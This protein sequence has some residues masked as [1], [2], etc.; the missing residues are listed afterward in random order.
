[1]PRSRHAVRGHALD[2]QVDGGD[3]EPLGADR[4]DDVRLRGGDLG[5]QV[6]AGHLGR[7]AHPG[8]QR[9]LVGE[10]LGGAGEDADPHRAAFA[11]VAGEGAG[12][13]AAD[14]DD[15]LPGQLLV[16]GAPGTPV[17][18]DAGRV[19]HDVA[20]DPDAAGLRVL[21]VDAGVADVRRGHHDDLAVVRRVGQRLLV[22][23]HA[24]GE[25]RLAEGLPHRSV[26]TAAEDAAVLQDEYG[27]HAGPVAGGGHR[28]PS[29]VV[30]RFSTAATQAACSA[31]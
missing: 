16:Q 17:G 11:Q 5:G 31:G 26:G 7:L 15:A 25:H 27:G 13:D 24:G 23:G 20:G 12:V 28:V 2:A 8:E 3:G 18:G 9:A 10:R 19:A 22:A 1:M 30:H 4:R 6:G 29:V 21:V 14:A